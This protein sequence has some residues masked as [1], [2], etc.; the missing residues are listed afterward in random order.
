MARLPRLG[1]KHSKDSRDEHVPDRLRVKASA[2]VRAFTANRVGL[3]GG[4]WNRRP[5]SCRG[6]RSDLV[7]VSSGV[8]LV[9]AGR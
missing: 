1:L 4:L 5:P 3:S 8:L 9:V 2:G 6:S 7:L